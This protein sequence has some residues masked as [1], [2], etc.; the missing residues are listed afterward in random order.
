VKPVPTF[1]ARVSDA[2]VLDVSQTQRQAMARW[3][4]TLKGQDVEIVVRKKQ[5]K[6]SLDQ[7]AYWHSVPVR[8]MA[9]EWGET[10]ERAHYLMLAE[11]RG[12]S[13]GPKG[14]LPNCTSSSKLTREEFSE[15]I[16]WVLEWGPSEWNC[17]I[18]A[19]NEVDLKRTA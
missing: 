9:E 11:W 1:P 3:C 16:T 7:N 10:P 18:P 12:Y 5:D 8:I 6:R 15:L 2:G 19:P 13:D 17:Y 4:K 14:P